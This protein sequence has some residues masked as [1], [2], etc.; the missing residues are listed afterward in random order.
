[1]I[2][3]LNSS[4]VKPNLN[5]EVSGY[6][7]CSVVWSL[8]ANRARRQ[9]DKREAPGKERRRDPVVYGRSKAKEAGFHVKNVE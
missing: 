6:P 7:Y 4:G 3:G 1:M 2:L 9:P 5:V 8:C